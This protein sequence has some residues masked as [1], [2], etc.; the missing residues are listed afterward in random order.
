MKKLICL[1]LGALILLPLTACGKKPGGS[2]AYLGSSSYVVK[3]DDTAE[4]TESK[5]KNGEYDVDMTSLSS[6]KSYSEICHILFAP[7]NFE[8]KLIRMKGR[9]DYAVNGENYYYSCVIEDAAGCCSKGLEFVLK[10]DRSFP[11]EYPKVGREFTVEG[12]FEIYEEGVSSFCRL[13]D[14]VITD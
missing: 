8:G 1:L 2:R 9:F 10:D 3:T 4:T 14:A 13:K 7:G 6:D 5:L 12:V 11:G